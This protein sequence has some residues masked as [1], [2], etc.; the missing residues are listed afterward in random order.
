MKKKII[1]L[2]VTVLAITMLAVP[3]M[4]KPTK[5]QKTAVTVIMTRNDGGGPGTPLSPNRNTGPIIHLHR[6]QGYDVTVTFEDS[7]TVLGNIEVERK[8]VNVKGGHRIVLT[9]YYVITLFKDELKTDPYDG[10]F[11]GNGQVLLDRVNGAS[12]AWG[13]F[14]GTEDFEGQTLN[15]GHGWE[16]FSST[17]NPWYGYWLKCS[18]YPM[19]P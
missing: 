4:A 10:G 3:V 18:V 2:L 17:P 1:M 16:A 8:M 5:G 7:S 13:L 14:H 11:E 12:L 9:D 19:T 6:L 15:I